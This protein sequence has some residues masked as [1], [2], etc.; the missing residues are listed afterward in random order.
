MGCQDLAD[1]LRIE[2]GGVFTSLTP[3]NRLS[4]MQVK[5]THP[6]PITGVISVVVDAASQG[7]KVCVKSTAGGQA[8][9]LVKTQVPL[10]NH[11]SRIAQLL[12]PL[13]KSDLVKG[14]TVGL[15]GPNDGVLQTRV[16]LIPTG[17]IIK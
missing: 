5:A 17:L 8:F 3:S 14:Q 10:A 15:P 9:L 7:A 11:V 2:V 1:S 4:L 6:R 12:Q 16:N 13:G